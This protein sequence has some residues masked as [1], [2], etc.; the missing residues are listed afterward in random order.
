MSTILHKPSAVATFDSV[1]YT[2][3]VGSSARLDAAAVP[4]ATATIQLPLLDDAVLEELDPRD[5]VRLPFVASD[6]GGTPRTFD[7]G[8]RSRTVDHA[9]KTVTCE[10]AGDE[11]L[12]SD[13]APIVDDTTPFTLAA[14]LRA[15]VNHVLGVVIPGAALEASA[16]DANVTPKWQVTQLMPNPSVRGIVGNWIPGGLNGILTRETF[17]LG[18]LSFLPDVTT[19]TLTGWSGNSGMGDGGAYGQTATVVPYVAARPFTEYTISV[20]AHVAVSKTVRLLSQIFGA[21]GAVLNGGAAV[22]TKMYNAVTGAQ[23]GGAATT[24][25][26]PAGT[27]VR[28]VGTFSTGALAA[29]IG[30][31]LYAA[32]T[33]QWTAGNNLRT[34]GWLVHEGSYPVPVKYFDGATPSDGIYTF[35]AVGAANA[36]ATVRT[37]I[38][39]GIDPD[40]LI[41]KTGVNAWDFLLPLTSAAGL[42]LYCDELRDWRLVTAEERSLGTQINVSP[43]NTRAGTDTLTRVDPDVWCTGI[44]VRYK[45]DDKDG[46]SHEKLDTAGTSGVLVEIV[47]N[48]PYPGPGAAA[49]ILARRDGLGRVQSVTSTTQYNTTPGMSVQI[50]LPGAPDT[51]GR[52]TAVDFDLAE[53]YMQLDTAGL[54]D[55]TPGDW[56]MV[57]ADANW[58]DYM[59][60]DTDWN[61]L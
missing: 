18:E 17:P 49:A 35:A 41:W 34:T 10:L 54:I 51:L 42:I 3:R 33:N 46:I 11:A 1:D 22:M 31:Y 44:I 28:L 53:G 55:V 50:S 24:Q 56:L 38:T 47:M 58:N 59:T 48:T 4:Y 14:S 23:I 13:H 32:L 20:Y 25:T 21:D 26:I 40:A 30:P 36:S 52:I 29:R 16:T 27:W 57:D 6:N 60:A 5:G 39:P 19:R 9:S 15:V 37:P 7:L 45:W 8:L 43:T 2:P 12:L 61:D